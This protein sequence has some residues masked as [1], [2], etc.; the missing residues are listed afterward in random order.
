MYSGALILGET[1]LLLDSCALIRIRMMHSVYVLYYIYIYTMVVWLPMVAT[2]F[3]CLNGKPVG[4][5][6]QNRQ[7]FSM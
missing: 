3:A 1:A 5:L 7:V 4:P 2:E 6:P